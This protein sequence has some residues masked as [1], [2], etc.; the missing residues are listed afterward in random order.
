MEEKVD[1]RR[2]KAHHIANDPDPIPVIIT[3]ALPFGSP[4]DADAVVGEW[5][6]PTAEQ[7]RRRRLAPPRVPPASG[8][9]IGQPPTTHG[10]GPVGPLRSP[11]EPAAGEGIV[12]C[13]CRRGP[14]PPEPACG[15]G[16]RLLSFEALCSLSARGQ[17]GAG[18]RVNGREPVGSGWFGLVRI[19]GATFERAHRGGNW[20]PRCGLLGLGSEV[21]EGSTTSIARRTNQKQS[22]LSGRSGVLR[23][24]FSV[25]MEAP[26]LL[27]DTSIY[28]YTKCIQKLCK[29]IFK[30]LVWNEEV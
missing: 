7:T 3:I 4:T 11:A 24:V 9:R 1:R 28:I 12:A 19:Q 8:G 16:C 17:G 30:S 26:F 15:R 23:V 13:R 20:D 10:P 18:P 27:I 14:R 29:Y 25:W 21:A 2:K 5:A 6:R 22:A